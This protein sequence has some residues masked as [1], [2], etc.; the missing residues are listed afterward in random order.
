MPDLRVRLAGVAVLVASTAAALLVAPAAETA[1]VARAKSPWQLFPGAKM[2]VSRPVLALG[3]A[4][5]RVW[6]VTP[7]NDV[8]ILHSARVSGGRL[9]SFAQTRVP[10]NAGTTIPI[11]DGQIVLQKADTKA[12]NEYTLTAT[13][14][15]MLPGGGLGAPKVVPD[16]LLARAKEA[17][18]KVWSAGIVNGVPVGNRVVW[19]LEAAPECHS[20]GGCRGFFLA[21]CAMNGAAVDL[22]R[23]VDPRENLLRYTLHMGRDARGRIW[24]A[25]LD[26]RNY[27]HAV[28]GVPRMLELDAST[29][30][31]RSQ[32]VAI[33]GVIT[34]RV[35]LACASSCR[36]VAQTSVGDIVSWTPGERSPT[37]VASHWERGKYGDGPMWLLAA[38]YRSGHLLVAYWGDK[39]KTIYADASVRNDIRVVRG[40]ARG[41]GV[42]IAAAIPVANTW[43]PQNPSASI[44]GPIIYGTF[45]PT[46]LVAVE[47]FQYVSAL[48]PLIGAFVP[49]GP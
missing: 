14:T 26:N 7:T 16:D 42:R 27:R 33:P 41:A 32:A 15:Q 31:P 29:L 24:L 10:T 47:T 34:D 25:W 12:S 44:A 11:V 43:P 46:G 8:P 48:S 36:V 40:D 17:V 21:C 30:A 4:A 6:T 19:A 5:N 38:A 3:W 1:P 35:E 22:T 9:A 28:R 49:S 37:R 45:T 2:D 18:P 39:G 13:T 20:I 23:F